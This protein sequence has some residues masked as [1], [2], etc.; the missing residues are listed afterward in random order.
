ME[1]GAVIAGLVTIA[2]LLV[3]AWLASSPQRAKEASDDKVQ[4]GRNDIVDGNV[5][6]VSQRID[7][8]CKDSGNSNA[9]IPSTEDFERR[10]R[11]L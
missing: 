5:G 4:Q 2:G 11:K 1:W 7:G 3:K 6:A 10:L 9:G 8:L